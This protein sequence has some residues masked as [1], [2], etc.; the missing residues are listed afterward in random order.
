[1]YCTDFKF[2]KVKINKIFLL[3]AFALR[4]AAKRQRRKEM[5]RE[6]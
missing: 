1:M 5:K 4:R 2:S 3:I 6:C